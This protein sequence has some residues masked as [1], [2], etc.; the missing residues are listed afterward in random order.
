M[1]AEH[2]G[3]CQRRPGSVT[4]HA[5]LACLGYLQAR[6]PALTPELRLRQPA[7]MDSEGPKLGKAFV[8]HS[9]RLSFG[10]RRSEAG[11]EG[12]AAHSMISFQLARVAE[13]VDARDLK[14]VR[15]KLP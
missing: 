15:K 1:E 13:L 9:L 4:C 12:K 3:T 11:E 5:R 8:V 14:S 10:I 2:L 6:W 7:C